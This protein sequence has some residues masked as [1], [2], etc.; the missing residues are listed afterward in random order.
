MADA[1][2]DLPATLR[3]GHCQCR[4]AALERAG[5]LRGWRLCEAAA[6]HARQLCA[7]LLGRSGCGAWMRMVF[8]GWLPTMGGEARAV[9]VK[10]RRAVQVKRRAGG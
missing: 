3:P 6:V 4:A 8:F 2:G 7:R 1:C 9:Q 5:G 10:N